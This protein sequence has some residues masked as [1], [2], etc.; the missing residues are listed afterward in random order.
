MTSLHAAIVKL[1]E[2][3]VA[4]DDRGRRRGWSDHFHQLAEAERD[5]TTALLTLIEI[6]QRPE[7]ATNQVDIKRTIEIW[8]MQ[9]HTPTEQLEALGVPLPL[10]PT[11]DDVALAMRRVRPSRRSGAGRPSRAKGTPPPE[12]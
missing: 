3:K 7:K 9:G 12:N 1:H 2:V 10:V 11:W 6:G 4:I 8:R 5:V